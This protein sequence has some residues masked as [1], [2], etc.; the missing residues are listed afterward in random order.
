MIKTNS[1]YKSPIIFLLVFLIL[2]IAPP[3]F[4]QRLA[5]VIGNA[6]YS[7]GP[8]SNPV[9]DAKDMKGVLKKLG[10]SVTIALNGNRK[11]MRKAIR[12]FGRSLEKGDVG[13]FY[14]AG[15]AV[16]VGGKNYLIPIGEDIQRVD[17]IVSVGVAIDEVINK[18]KSVRNETN[19]VFL[20]ACRDNPYGELFENMTLRDKRS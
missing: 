17:E 4:S 15:H 19:L 5:L 6:D 10:F 7:A 11:E 16:E 12:L 8:L 1:L 20:D 3:A 14:Y 2:S 18:M 9:N 13:L